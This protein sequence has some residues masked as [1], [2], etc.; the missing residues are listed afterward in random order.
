MSPAEKREFFTNI[1]NQTCNENG[2]DINDYT[3]Q[4]KELNEFLLYRKDNVSFDYN[5]IILLYPEGKIMHVIV[6]NV[7]PNFM[8][9][10]INDLQ[11]FLT[12]YRINK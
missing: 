9:K 6:L 11:I 1:F 7:I 12:K 4:R 3:I 8:S 5:H 10:A 2:I